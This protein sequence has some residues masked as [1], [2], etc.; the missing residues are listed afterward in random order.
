MS[1]S[2]HDVPPAW[3][4]NLNAQEFRTFI[5]LVERY[6]AERRIPVQVKADEGVVRPAAGVFDHS[7][8][9]GLQ[10]VAQ[11]CAQVAVER[12]PSLIAEHFDCIFAVS[13]DQNALTVD[14]GDFG[15]VSE[16]LRARLY[17]VDLL[18]QSVETIHRPGPE[19]TI[20]VIVLDLPTTVRTISRS[21]AKGW[22]LETTELFEIG[23]RNLRRAGLLKHTAVA[24]R[25]GVEIHLYSGD[26][27]YAASHALILDAYLPDDLPH[28]ALVGL[29]RRDAILLHIIRNIGVTEAIG[30][31]LQAIVGMYA[32]GPGS[33]SPNLYWFWQGE[34]I[35]LPYELDGNVLDFSPPADFAELLQRLGESAELS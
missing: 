20:E 15:K 23:R 17:P 29:P 4:H 18:S 11:A 21:E 24:V 26:P 34:F 9:F 30:S 2:A 33:L 35:T 10:N 19:G 25:P 12:W 13:S 28:G 31:M 32:D 1:G 8:V 16:R 14:V 3:A 5:A 22:A 7:S 27:Y 6:F